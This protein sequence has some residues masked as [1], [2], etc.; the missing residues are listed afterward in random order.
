M[1][2]RTI[3]KKSDYCSKTIN[4]NVEVIILNRNEALIIIRGIIIIIK[5]E[6]Q[7]LIAVIKKTE[8]LTVSVT[9][10]KSEVIFESELNKLVFNLQCAQKQIQTSTTHLVR[11]VH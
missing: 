2:R 5:V 3:N 9:K 1:D 8:Q 6:R 7:L 10:M 4:W 11:S